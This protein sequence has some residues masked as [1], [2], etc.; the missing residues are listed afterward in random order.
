LAFAAG[1]ILM[2]ASPAPFPMPWVLPG[3]GLIVLGSQVY[4]LTQSKEL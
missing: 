2:M 4:A 3:I 1:L